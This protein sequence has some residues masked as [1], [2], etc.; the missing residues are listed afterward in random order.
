MPNL[1]IITVTFNDSS[2]LLKTMHSILIQENKPDQWIVI[3]GGSKYFD[4]EFKS[5]L[6]VRDVK[7]DIISEPDRGIY[8]AMNKGLSLVRNMNYVLFLNAGDLLSHETL[9]SLINSPGF[10]NYETVSY[11]GKKIRNRINDFRYGLPVVHQSIIFPYS[12][13]RYDTSFKL[14]AD[15]DFYLKHDLKKFRSSFF[16]TKGYVTYQRGGLSDQKYILLSLERWRIIF[17]NFGTFHLF[18]AIGI[19]FFKIAVKLF[20]PNKSH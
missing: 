6:I 12:A 19:D 4:E 17:R 20:L 14:S 3:D 10:L 18:K 2:S 11:F 13:F 1:T 15:Y 5:Q 16:D 7:V 8:D 9:P